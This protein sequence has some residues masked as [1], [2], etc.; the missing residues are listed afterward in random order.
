MNLKHSLISGQSFTFITKFSQIINAVLDQLSEEAE[1][2]DLEIFMRHLIIGLIDQV[3]EIWCI[4]E[5]FEVKLE[6]LCPSQSNNNDQLNSFS[7]QDSSEEHYSMSPP[8][9]NHSSIL[10]T[11]KPRRKSTR[12]SNHPQEAVLLLKEWLL[13]NRGDP[14]PKPHE[15]ANLCKQTGLTVTQLNDWFVNG[16]RRILG[17]VAQSSTTTNSHSSG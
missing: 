2:N 11:Q 3:W 12:K 4:Y 17:R 14:Y 9:T 8:A 15:K 5:D 1:V 6:G 13:N 7:S 10:P 16:R